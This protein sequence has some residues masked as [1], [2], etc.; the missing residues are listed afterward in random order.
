MRSRETGQ[1]PKTH[2][3]EGGCGQ[4]MRNVDDIK[5]VTCRA[6]IAE[7][8]RTEA[9]EAL[10]LLNKH[11]DP[12]VQAAAAKLRA[13]YRAWDSVKRPEVNATLGAG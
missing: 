4:P 5:D 3:R 1:D 6:C 13:L 9:Q 2:L 12:N 8:V 11:P 7:T 10:Q